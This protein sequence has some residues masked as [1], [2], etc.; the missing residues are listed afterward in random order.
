MAGGNRH[1]MDGQIQTGDVVVSHVN[2]TLDFYIIATVLSAVE[3]LTLHSISTMKGQDA[4]IMRGYDQR[5][6]DRDVW[7]FG[8]SAA[9]YVKAPPAEELMSRASTFRLSREHLAR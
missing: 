3:D 2:G 5:K 9:A 4:A 6:D 8:G 1:S 7:L